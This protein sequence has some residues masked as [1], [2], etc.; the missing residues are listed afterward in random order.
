M[1]G[2]IKCPHCGSRLK[3]RTSREATNTVREIYYQCENVEC[4]FTCKAHLALVNTIAPSMCPRTGVY[5]PLSRITER[6]AAAQT[7]QTSL[8]GM[9]TMPHPRAMVGPDSG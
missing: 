2:F 4:A 3:T 5:I 9:D 1:S 7:A 8:P 6:K